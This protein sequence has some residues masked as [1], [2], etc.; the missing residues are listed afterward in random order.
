MK[1]LF[2]SDTHGLHRK[3]KNMPHADMLIHAGDVS[4]RGEDHEIEDF[5][6]W[7]SKQDYQYKIFIAG[8]HDF[9]FENETTNRIQKMLPQNT[10]Y[11]CD[12]GVVIEEIKFW[13]SPITPT[14][15][16]W[17]FNRDRG[18]NIVK[19]WNKI[20]KNTDVLITH[21]PP[22]G[23]LDRTKSGL[24]VG[25]E[26]LLKKVRLI[27]PKYHLFGHIHEHYG[28]YK[29]DRIFFVN[30]SILDENYMM[31]NEPIIIEI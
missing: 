26:D 29:D 11:L 30:G 8:N 9:Y 20:P 6:N 24:N 23:V 10:Y 15:F 18:K 17:A 22:F 1:I 5:I 7:F 27:Q 4:K 3:L 2:M 12:T 28:T 19:Y 13:G 14:F 16:N 25:C 21:G 31:T